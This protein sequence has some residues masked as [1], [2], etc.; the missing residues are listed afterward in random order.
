M[1]P[2]IEEYVYFDEELKPTSDLIRVC[3]GSFEEESSPPSD[4]ELFMGLVFSKTK[5]SHPRGLVFS[6]KK[7]PHPWGLVF[8]KKKNPHPRGLVFSKKKNPHPW[9]L[10]FLKNNKST[11]LIHAAWFS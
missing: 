2:T 1:K 8:S 10:V 7:N 6:K 9:G 4:E 5:N 3:W 11:I